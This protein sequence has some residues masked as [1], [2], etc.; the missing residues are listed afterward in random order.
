M[1]TEMAVRYVGGVYSECRISEGRGICRL[2][3]CCEGGGEAGGV[4][5]EKYTR[6]RMT[7]ME[8]MD[9]C[10]ATWMT[11]SDC[12]KQFHFVWPVSW[13]V[14]VCW[15]GMYGESTAIQ[16]IVLHDE[17]V[18]KGGGAACAAEE[19]EVGTDSLTGAPSNNAIM[20]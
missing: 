10:N 8:D 12:T 9:H 4:V 6:K 14:C 15:G 1:V 20:L 7:M 2:S 3:W 18:E 19:E 17:D 13:C 5:V 16:D 11:P